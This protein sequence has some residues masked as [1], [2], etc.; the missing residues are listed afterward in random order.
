M[1]L[2]TGLRPI[3]WR[4]LPYIMP[5]VSSRVVAQT[6]APSGPGGS[7]AAGDLLVPLIS[8]LGF[9]A[10]IGFCVGFLL[11]KVGKVAAIIVG[12]AFVLLQVLAHYDIIVIQWEPIKGWWDRSTT[13]TQLQG[14]WATLRT[15][16]FANVPALGGAIPGF[17]LGFKMG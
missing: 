8:Q 7:D 6:T 13:P 1:L 4:W 14:H 2:G 9:G 3:R 17:I 5:F 11:K 10:V 15:I 12:L 16:L